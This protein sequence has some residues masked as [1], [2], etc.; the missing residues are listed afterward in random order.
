MSD[1]VICIIRSASKLEKAEVRE[2]AEEVAS[3]SRPVATFPAPLPA[4]NLSQQQQ[5]IPTIAKEARG[6]GRPR[7]ASPST[8]LKRVQRTLNQ[9][10]RGRVRAELLAGRTVAD[11]AKT[12][13]IGKTTVRRIAAEA[14]PVRPRGGVVN[15][16]LTPQHSRLLAEWVSEDPTMTGAMLSEKLKE[17]SVYVTPSTVNAR[18]RS[19]VMEVHGTQR[20]TVKKLHI[21]EESR[22][23]ESVKAQRVEFVENYNHLT[24]GG[25]VVVFL[26]ETP[27][28]VLDNR[29]L[30]RAPVGQRA[31]VYRRRVRTYGATAITA[32]AEPWGVFHVEFVL[33]TV[34]AD[35][36]KIFLSGLFETIRARTPAAVLL[37]MDNVKF[38]KTAGVREM[39][40]AS[41]HRVL[42]TAPWSCELNPIEYVFGF[43]KSRVRVPP[44]VTTS[45]GALPFIVE[46][47]RSATLQEVAST[48][49]F[50]TETMF[51]RAC[52]RM[53]LQLKDA[54]MEFWLI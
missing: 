19:H 20:F 49:R 11:V 18:L 32:I 5:P 17:C 4:E 15:V 27:F 14:G 31:I 13:G 45:Q 8:A 47:F 40:E 37:V 12:F 2:I 41:G 28:R 26:D 21:H 24:S 42:Y 46:G 7:I 35:V 22:N 48:V 34:S 23:S 29:H 3:M 16:K 44:E 43:V 25:C 38:H 33:G 10:D 54:L 6:R 51:P 52:A 30:A 36:F 53:D 50:V 9:E 1:P 39:I